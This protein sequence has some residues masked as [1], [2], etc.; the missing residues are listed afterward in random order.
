MT[1]VEFYV[2]VPDRLAKSV[3]L[4]ARA[5]NKGRQITIF[6]PDESTS[7]QL[8]QQLWQ[9]SATSF[10]TN[11]Q[12]HEPSSIFS[13]IVLDALGEQLLQDDVLINLQEQHPPFFS[14]FRHLIEIVSEDAADKMAAR[15]RYKFYKDRGYH[16]KTT[17]VTKGEA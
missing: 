6:T 12:Q 9:H 17:D 14:R 5:V 4:C 15:I 13:A 2:N 7:A 8:Q 1:R 10:F 16:I 3:E 11:A